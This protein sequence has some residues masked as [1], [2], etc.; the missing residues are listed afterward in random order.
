[1]AF[2]PGSQSHTPSDVAGSLAA[3]PLFIQKHSSRDA[4]LSGQ[5]TFAGRLSLK[6]AFVS[7]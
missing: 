2:Q 4:A 7:T 3:V 5:K 6:S 1:M